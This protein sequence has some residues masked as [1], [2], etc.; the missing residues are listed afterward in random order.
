MGRGSK[1]QPEEKPRDVTT[2]RLDKFLK[3]SRIIK[4]RSVANDAADTG[5]V[6][7]NGKEAKPSADV[8]VGDVIAVRFGERLTKYEVVS[9]SEHALKADAAGMYRIVP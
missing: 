8:R 6:T 9:L 5:H 4:R 7:V 1:N 3:V 2:M